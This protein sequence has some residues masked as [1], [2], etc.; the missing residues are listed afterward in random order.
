LIT[1]SPAARSNVGRLFLCLF[2]PLAGTSSKGLQRSPIWIIRK[3]MLMLST[4][5]GLNMCNPA[6]T[7]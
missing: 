4:P 3:R 1:K 7:L 5:K 2:I 6:A